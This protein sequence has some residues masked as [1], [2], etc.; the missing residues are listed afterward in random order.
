MSLQLFVRRAG[1]VVIIELHGR[2]TIGPAHDILHSWLRRLIADGTKKVLVGLTDVTQ[3]DSLSL[4][5]IVSAYVSLK[6][7][8]ASLKLLRPRGD[9]RLVLE[10]VHLLDVIPTIEDETR[11][12]VSFQ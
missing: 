8:D 1:D 4:G 9:V 6:L 7:R 5:S 10:T 3:L 2:A 12:I 11:A